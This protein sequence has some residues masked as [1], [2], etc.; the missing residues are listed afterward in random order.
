MKKLGMIWAVLTNK[1]VTV[2]ARKNDQEHCETFYETTAPAA[3]AAYMASCACM[4]AK[5][6]KHHKEQPLGV[7]CKNYEPFVK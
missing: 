5:S 6:I 3:L 1:Y 7:A 2:Y 4:S